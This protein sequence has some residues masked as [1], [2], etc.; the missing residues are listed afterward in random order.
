M[1]KTFFITSSGTEIGKTFIT[2]ALIH[3]MKAAG[4]SIAAFK[5]LLSGFDEDAVAETDTGILLKALGRKITQNTINEMTPWR[6]K[7]A[8]SPDM[9]AARE[10]K[11]IE[12]DALIEFT[13]AALRGGDDF[14]L[15][16]GVGGVM[17]PIGQAHTVLDW[18]GA[19]Q[20]PA[21]LVVGGYLGT[22]S[23]TLTA[24]KTLEAAQ[25]PLAGVV[26]SARGELPVSPEETAAAI[27]RFLPDVPVAH[28]PDCGSQDTAWRNAPDL[29]GD[30]CLLHA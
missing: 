10:G 18:I 13:E 8:L 30:L 6:Y 7:A 28:L 3:Q 9:A 17:A 21:I 14:T 22:I 19:A 26:I 24:A 1:T 27:S 4:K 23:H 11:T 29:L 5:P 2:A 25:V 16:E 15:L 20:C 12:F